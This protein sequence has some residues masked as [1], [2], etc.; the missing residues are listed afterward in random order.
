MRWMRFLCSAAVVLASVTAASSQT[1]G[2]DDRSEA[3]ERVALPD[4]AMSQQ[5]LR[6]RAAALM[7][8]E[9]DEVVTSSIRVPTTSGRAQHTVTA[10][11]KRVMLQ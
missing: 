5:E 10:P 8:E 1:N 3:M 6:E 2:R 4:D 7:Q 9:R 11:A